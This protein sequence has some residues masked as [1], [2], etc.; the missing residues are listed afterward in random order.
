MEANAKGLASVA[1][2]SEE[3]FD[4]HERQLTARLTTRYTPPR[5]ERKYAELYDV[6][7]DGELVVVGSDNPHCDLARVLLALGYTGTVIMLDAETGNH[8][9]TVKIEK[10]ARLTVRETER[11]GPRFVRW[12]R[13]ERGDGPRWSREGGQS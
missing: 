4:G 12:K 8:R 2:E 10:A 9:T 6:E 13:F 7:F 11:E 3:S 5:A 1:A